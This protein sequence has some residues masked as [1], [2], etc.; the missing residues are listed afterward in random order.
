MPKY[1]Y[2]CRTCLE[3]NEVE[4]SIHAEETDM[5]CP[6]CSQPM[7]RVYGPIGVV[8]KGQGFY[9]TDKDPVNNNFYPENGSMIP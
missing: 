9:K 6:T 7:Q 3:W 4:R 8:L 5:L 2:H 1:D